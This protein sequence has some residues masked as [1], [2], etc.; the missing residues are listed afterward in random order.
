M[1]H[2]SNV[3]EFVTSTAWA[4]EPERHRQMMQI[5]LRRADGVRLSDEDLEAATGRTEPATAAPL[6]VDKGVATIPIHGVIAHRAA[7]VGRISSRVGTSVEGIRADLQYALDN[8]DVQ[9]IVLD[10][11]SPGGSV[12]G[13][14]DL[15][16]EI[17]AARSVKPIVAHTDA[18]MASAAYW[19]ASQANKIV[20]TRSAAVGSI[21]VIASFVDTHR[22]MANDG[23]DPVVVKSVPGKGGT[24]SN[25][26]LSDADRA[27]IQREVDA[28]HGLFIESVAAGRGISIDAAKTL[29]DGKV[30]L[31]A[32]AEARGLVD[33]I[34]TRKGALREARHLARDLAALHRPAG[35]VAAG[36][37][38]QDDEEDTP[39]TE[40]NESAAGKQTPATGPDQAPAPT[41]DATKIAAE[42]AKAATEAERKRA[43]DILEAADSN[44]RELA[45]KL[46]AENVPFADAI[47]ALTKDRREKLS[48]PSSSPMGGG[49]T[50][51]NKVT[52]DEGARIKAMPEGPEKWKAEFEANAD[53][54]AEFID[55]E[56]YFGW[57]RNEANR[58][59][60]AR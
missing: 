33:A 40:K 35:D 22:A 17:R 36:A 10:V 1:N 5:L 57:K 9:A 6:Q 41:I 29:G 46:I 54:K 44:Q 14:D 55:A 4:M 24:Q 15:A 32:D 2:L 58:Q 60:T 53:L 8:P 42:A 56:T 30:Y 19:L 38:Q 28:Y 11:D 13:I 25:G 27:D 49:N 51:G 21:G 43:A 18:L 7:A 34:G 48:P 45:A 47:K 12:A 16:A 3:L 52:A 59:S 31:G 39:M 20:A 37:H 23:Y 50:D 26:T